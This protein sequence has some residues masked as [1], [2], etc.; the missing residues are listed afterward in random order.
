M[1]GA[2]GSG[3]PLILFDI[4]GTL[5]WTRGAGRAAVREAMLEIFGATGAIE[6]HTFG[7]K[8][9]WHTLTELL[10]PLGYTPLAIAARMPAFNAALG[11]WT[12][13][14]I[15]RYAVEACP[16]ALPLVRRLASQAGV[17][18]GLVTGNCGASAPVKLRAAGFD[19]AWFPV[20]GFGHEAVQRNDLPALAVQRAC[21]HYACTFEAKQVL[22][23]GDTVADVQ[24]ARACGARVMAVRTGFEDPTLLEASAP[25]ALIDDLTQFEAAY[26]ML[27]RA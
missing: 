13:Q 26:E 6:A 15:G 23:V 4:D 17:A 16:G 24:C 20:G 10:T 2:N 5:L 27:L 14:V 9:D 25:D 18:L 19:P 22:V 1:A 11:R 12:E 8:T 3:R 7:G 21:A